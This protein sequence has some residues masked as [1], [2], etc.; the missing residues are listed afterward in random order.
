MH[1]TL[2]IT[3]IF[4]G[5]VLASPARAQSQPPSSTERREALAGIRSVIQTAVDKGVIAGA[6]VHVSRSGQPLLREAFGQADV[7]RPMTTDALFRIASMTKP[8]T[9]VAV[10]MLV[11]EGRVRLDDPLARYLPEFADL[12]VRDAQ[13]GELVAPNRA[14]TIRD[15]LSH[16]SGIAYGFA[17]P[18]SVKADYTAAA[19]ADGL[20]PRDPDLAENTRMLA[21][22][23]LAHQ[24][25]AAFTY[26]MNTD[27]LGR[28]IEVASGQP[29]DRFFAERVFDPLKMPDTGF[30][31]P[32][33]KRSRLTAIYRPVAGAH[34]ARVEKV[35]SDP[36][37]AGDVTYS[38]GRVVKPPQYLSAG[39]GLVS[40]AADYARFLT[41]LMRE[42]ALDGVQLLRPESVRAMTSNQIGQLSC[43][44]PIHGEKFGL[45][46]GITAKAGGAAPVG[47]YSWGGIYYTF[48]W[49]DPQNEMVA[50]LMTQLFPW[51]EATL[52]ADFQKAVY[53]A[54]ADGSRDAPPAALTGESAASE[55]RAATV[56]DAL[57]QQG[58]FLRLFWFEKGIEFGNPSIN[59]R[60]RVNDPL[61]ALHPEFGRRSEARGNGMLQI[62]LTEPLSIIQAAELALELWGGHPGTA[63]KRVT[64]NGR[65][66]YLIAEIGT[67]AGNCTHQYPVIRLERSDLVQAQNSFQFACDRGESFWGHFIVDNACLRVELGAKHP[68]LAESHLAGFAA[69]VTTLPAE[70]P[71]LPLTLETPGEFRDL[72][73]GVDFQGYY[74]G[75]DENGD[76]L[77][78][79]WHGM[80]KARRPYEQLGTA[81]SPPF[82]ITWDTAMLSPQRDM[83]AR[84]VVRF[85][86]HP[87]LIYVTP[88]LVGLATPLRGAAVR[89][90]PAAELPTSFWSRADRKKSCDIV[91]DVEPDSLG[92]AELR[93]VIW[94]GGVDKIAEPLSLNG[95]PLPF[96]SDG[97]HDVKSLRLPLLPDT[98]RKG[99][100]T[101]EVHSDTEHHGIE[102]LLPG[103]ELFVRT[104]STS[105]ET[106]HVGATPAAVGAPRP[107][108]TP[109]VGVAEQTL[110]G[111]MECLVI[112]TPAA[113][114]YYGK[115]GAGFARILDPEGH[116]WISYQPGGKAA[117][118]YRGLPKSGQ[119]VK[120]FHCGY[121]FGQYATTN[122]FRTTFTRIGPEHVRVESETM[123]GA[124]AAAWDFY[125]E[126]ATM[127]LRRIPGDRYW[128]LYEGTPGGAL[129]VADDFVLRPGGRRTQLST[130]WKE[131][132]PWVAFTARESP[133]AL[134][135]L[136]HQE[137]SPV[138]SYVSW[139][140]APDADGNRHQMTVFGFGRPDW[141]SPD[142]HTPQLTGLPARFTIALVEA[143]A[144]ETV[145][146][147]V[148]AAQTV[149]APEDGF[150]PLFDG[151]ALGKWEG[152]PALWRV[153]G[154]A[155]VGETTAEKQPADG[156]NTFLI[157]RGGEFADFELRFRYKVEGFNSG[158]QFRSVDRGQ[159]H[160]DG[161]QADFEAR[162]HED[163]ATAGTLDKFSGMFFEENGRMFMAQ[164]GE[165]VIVRSNPADP[166]KPRI[167][168]IARLGDP[169][170]LEKS[171]RRDDWNDYVI[172]ANGNVFTHIINGQVMSLAIDED[173]LN[174]RKSGVL[175]LQLHSGKPM[176]I[177]VKDIRLREMPK[178][179][180]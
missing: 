139:P 116:D 99:K 10:M 169:Q 149:A 71:S 87:D 12:R 113:K 91:L 162:W 49:V 141:Q 105:S 59:N 17:A 122:P 173:E 55:T 57:A 90:F 98:L 84:A 33:E 26:G 142:Q 148:Q 164:R 18:D 138:D 50:V 111:D 8:V 36:E 9:S 5:F 95:R 77:T 39:A 129:D 157:Y 130:P 126:S 86:N 43:A 63:H 76:G 108:E 151:R 100:N 92:A 65:S 125:P 115:R 75:F 22:L 47:A 42:G 41:M 2:L 177:E 13:S 124:A 120:Y 34:P 128:F 3:A 109:R 61:V 159:F 53:A 25:G 156:K 32:P 179:A 146:A 154:G 132:V 166:K 106:P 23:P 117:G 174:F 60:F 72:I 58:R 83:A 163:P 167:E 168:K 171:I 20:N 48:F 118:E 121:G 136:N 82:H 102:V 29:L 54:T 27:V 161:L 40:T 158:M 172:I 175:A 103:P 143:N 94:D 96:R 79:D 180:K 78:R 81:D 73:A 62:E 137:R 37:R 74:D 30:F 133:Y 46:F 97:K 19:L 69:H 176:R 178:R 127:T 21:R 44:F 28:V 135:C 45:G 93:V 123:D 131:V 88:P 7:E 153:A 16:V 112:D 24:P 144:A 170:E 119:P 145:V 104:K 6:V 152:D 140:Y 85:R 67:A 147:Q 56:A 70:G 150:Q 114:Y 107:G 35:S 31:V 155:I 80:T 134:L 11:E 89:R 64:V 14:V 110:F 51:G 38:A 101:F 68:L 52:W 1:R 66:T 15:L 160:V 4:G 165:A